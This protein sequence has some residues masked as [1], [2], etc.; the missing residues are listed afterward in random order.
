[1]TVTNLDT[2]G[3]SRWVNDVH[4]SSEVQRSAILLL[5]SRKEPRTEV[6]GYTVITDPSKPVA[7]LSRKIKS[8]LGSSLQV[9]GTRWPRPPSSLHMETGMIYGQAWNEGLRMCCVD[10]Q[11]Y[12]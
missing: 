2:E 4:P 6:K 1:M 12:R 7:K 3:E 8:L 10:N 9:Q 5:T 11:I